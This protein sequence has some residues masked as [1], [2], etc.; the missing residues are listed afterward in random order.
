MAAEPS[1]HP[2]VGH[3]CVPAAPPHLQA[4][5]PAPTRSPTGG[6]HRPE[7]PLRSASD[8]HRP[9]L[10]RAVAAPPEPPAPTASHPS[11]SH[12]EPTKFVGRLVARS[13]NSVA[14]IEELLRF[15]PI[16]LEATDKV[17]VEVTNC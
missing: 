5:A 15:D 4:A 7:R 9:A 16:L 1:S 11:I 6:S 10:R 2:H 8:P 17:F 3:A 12:T 14:K 13:S